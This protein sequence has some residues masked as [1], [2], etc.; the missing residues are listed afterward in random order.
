MVLDGQM[1][2]RWFHWRSSWIRQ[3]WNIVE[4][5]GYLNGEQLGGKRWEG[6]LCEEFFGGKNMTNKTLKF[7]E[8]PNFKA[9]VGR[10]WKSNVKTKSG[11][12]PYDVLSLFTSFH[13]I[14]WSSANDVLL[15]FSD[16][17]PSIHWPH[18]WFSADEI[19]HSFLAWHRYFF[20]RQTAT[21]LDAD[22]EA[23]GIFARWAD[24]GDWQARDVA[25]L[26]EKWVGLFLR[27]SMEKCWKLMNWT[28]LWS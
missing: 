27:K 18:V 23:D 20:S 14:C 3:S 10:C 5:C 8:F 6:N 4:K 22:D 26:A 15:G 11:L 9:H 24:F 16:L 17:D 25:G 13:M 19:S 7:E 21:M 2:F 12:I 28:S 1:G